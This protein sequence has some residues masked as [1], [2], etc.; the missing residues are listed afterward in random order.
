MEHTMKSW[1]IDA[2]GIDNLELRNVAVPK[3]QKGEILVKVA[4]ISLNYRD[5][6]VIETGRGLE[7]SFPFSPG[8]DLSGTVIEVGEGANHFNV[9]DKVITTASPD[10]I[11]G[12]RPGNAKFPF[13]RTLGGYYSGVMSEYVAFSEDWF[14]RAPVSL[15]PT[16]ASTLPIAGLTAWFA[17]SERAHLRAGDTVLIPSTGGVALFG[18]LI[19]KAQGAETIVVGHSENAERVKALGATYFIEKDKEDW[20]E[21]VF[22]ITKNRGVDVTLEVIGGRNLGKSVQLTA[23]GGHICQIGALDGFDLSA[24][25]MPLMLKDITIHGIGTGSRKGL[26]N[27]IRA[28]DQ[29]GLKPVIDTIYKFED[30]PLALDHLSRG[31]FGKIVLELEKSK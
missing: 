5:K 21:R 28:V 25:A 6:M 2:I 31:A 13:Y 9:G 3:P 23:V 12:L 24:P 11:D 20:V 19:A 1:Q 16:E 29:T 27:L 10:W 7:L 4:A 30:L 17:L 14:V 8:S 18:L 22:E 15:D 26:E